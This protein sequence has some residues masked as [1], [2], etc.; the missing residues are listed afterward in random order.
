MNKNALKSYAPRARRDFIAAVT[1]RAAKFGVSPQKV[2]PIRVEGDF[3]I[4]GGTPFPRTVADQRRRL[5]GRIAAH[6]FAQVREAAAYT[7]FNRLAAI[8][9]MEIHGYLDHG[10]RVLSH[11]TGKSVPEII[12]Q[13]D[14]VDLPGLNRDKV[15]EL[16]LDGRKDEDLYRMLLIAQCNALHAAMPFLF[17]RIDDETELLL[18]D[19][20]L[21]TDS[22]IRQ[23]VAEI[24]EDDWKEIEV[25]GWLYQ[26]YIAERK[27]EVIGKVVKSEDIPA[28]TQLFTPNWI[29][30]YMVQN[31]LGAKWLATYPHSPL[32]AKMEYYIEPA[33]Q[34]EEVNR[35][36]ADIT[37]AALDPEKLTMIDPACGSGHILV[38]GYDLLKE[39]YL[40]RG[41]TLRQIPRLILEENLYGLDIDDRAAQLAGFALM[42]KARADDRNILQDP[43]LLNVMSLT[44]SAGLDAAALADALSPSGKIEL[45]PVV[46]LLPETL[47]QPGLSAPLQSVE[48]REAIKT[49]SDLFNGAKTFGSLIVVPPIL[50]DSLPRL[51]A[52]LASAAEGDMLQRQAAIH[53]RDILIPLV[54]QARILGRHYDCV[55]ANPPYMGQG[56]FPDSLKRFIDQNLKA[57]NSNLYAAFMLRDLLLLRDDGLSAMINIPQWMFAS[58]FFDLRT[59]IFATSMISSACH[60]GRGVFGS[61]FGSVA[62]VQRKTA[63]REFR[64]TYLRLFDIKGG[65]STNEDI[66]QRFF[67]DSRRYVRSIRELEALPKLSMG[68][69]AS[70]TQL[71]AFREMEPI[72][73]FADLNAGLSTGDN[74]RFQ[75]HWHEVSYEHFA[76]PQYFQ[77]S[78]SSNRK[79]VPCNSGGDFRKWYGNNSITVNWSDNG[80]EIRQVK[81]KKGKIASAIRNEESYFQEGF[82]WN[83]ITAANTSVRYFGPGF[84][85]DDTGRSGFAGAENL[86]I[87]GFLCSRVAQKFLELLAPSMSFTSGEMNAL[88]YRRPSE[89]TSIIVSNCISI[90]RSDWDD[91]ETSWDF[92]QSPLLHPDRR[93]PSL[94]SIYA[95]LRAHWQGMTDEVQRLE[96]EN[97]L[98]FIEAYALAGELNPDVPLNEI[99]LTCNPHYRY[100]GDLSDEV[101][102]VR[103]RTDTIRDM[104]SYAIGCM[105][106]R[107]S[108]ARPGLIY[109]NESNEGFDRSCYG[110]FAASADGLLPITQDDWFADGAANRMPEF[111]RVAFTPDTVSENLQFIADSL[112]PKADETPL[113]TIRRYISRDYFRDHLQA[114]K[115]RPIYWLFSSGKEKAFECLVYLHRY[116]AGTLSRMRMEYVVPL[117]GRMRGKIEQI[118]AAI[119]DASSTA[120]QTKLRKELEK[121]K[122]KQAELV[123][124]DEELRH[125]ADQRIELDLD[126]GVKVNYAKFGNLLSEVKK[127]SGDSDE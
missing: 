115:F 63:V 68:Y 87:M 85:F 94:S 90:A 50:L 112:V 13:A 62:F 127:I 48:T 41:Y 74:P 116:N 104:I 78:S 42:M 103:L 47:P 81:N 35:Q 18:P 66:R 119:K 79:W 101:L 88:P 23:M 75:R 89:R 114:Y 11:P 15:V 52:I 113:D 8:R 64:G 111:L 1:A 2:E 32:R 27:D 125:F 97:N 26:F 67:E 45:L 24:D 91:Y 30:K 118:D 4:I 106:G 20:L 80:R 36:L 29:V 54:R 107:Y 98:L 69:W 9:Y 58:S 19:N 5:E 34:T 16:K 55:V 122:K 84:V 22:L 92:I 44:E 7:W 60:N 38:E 71:R 123:K 73:D 83:K 17:E 56:F 33:I 124:F 31:S 77:A 12:E 99:T 39:I 120:A 86:P 105:M 6:G 3:A 110:D 108:L 100:G 10:Y 126:D 49:I 117:Q 40:E 61:D 82:T 43:P 14:H 70:N 59:A 72:S 121:L 95:A 65:V 109:A 37:P 51:E 28:A 46:D 102:E 57:G 21:H 25:I 96:E 53:A 93:Q 76:S